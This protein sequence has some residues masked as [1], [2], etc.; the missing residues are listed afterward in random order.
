MEENGGWGE[1]RT[2]DTRE[3]MPHFECGAFNR[4]ATHPLPRLAG[5]AEPI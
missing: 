5:W 4:S 3:G 1:I 2:P